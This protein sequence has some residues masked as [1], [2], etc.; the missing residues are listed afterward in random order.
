MFQSAELS[1]QHEEQAA[2]PPA[3]QSAEQL[4]AFPKSVIQCDR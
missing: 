2:H 1:L 3:A 4:P